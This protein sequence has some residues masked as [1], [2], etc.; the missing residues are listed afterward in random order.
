MLAEDR[1]I[2]ARGSF[3]LEVACFAPGDGRRWRGAGSMYQHDQRVRDVEAHMGLEPVSAVSRD[4]CVL[5]G[6]RSAGAGK[7]SWWKAQRL[8][9][10]PR[11]G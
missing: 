10:W 6:E 11:S 2:V 8:D 7:R 4:R 3:G 9:R 1:W 5:R